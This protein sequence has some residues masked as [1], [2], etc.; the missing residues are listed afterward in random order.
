MKIPKLFGF[1]LLFEI[2]TSVLVFKKDNWNLP[3]T[4]KDSLT[5]CTKQKCWKLTFPDAD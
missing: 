5:T 1:F 3:E 2:F 4:E